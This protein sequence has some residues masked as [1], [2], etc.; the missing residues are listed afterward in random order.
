LA[1]LELEDAEKLNIKAAKEE[2]D[3]KKYLHD[4]TNQSQSSRKSRKTQN[5]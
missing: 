4:F 3:K 5:P 2:E 1:P